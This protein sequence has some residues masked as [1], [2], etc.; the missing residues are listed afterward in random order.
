MLLRG[1]AALA[2]VGRR[3][4]QVVTPDGNVLDDN[5]GQ[6]TAFLLATL[7]MIMFML[8]GPLFFLC[9]CKSG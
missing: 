2:D 5:H 3:I 7:L 4:L 6:D 1:E 8:S 9:F